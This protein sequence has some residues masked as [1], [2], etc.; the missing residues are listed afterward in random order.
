MPLVPCSCRLRA[1][2]TDLARRALEALARSSERLSQLV[3]YR[4]FGGLTFDEIAEA[5]GW[6]VPTVKRDWARARAWL[7]RT[8]ETAGG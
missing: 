4:F 5:T 8:L 1:S 7:Y 6:S 2:G 3:E